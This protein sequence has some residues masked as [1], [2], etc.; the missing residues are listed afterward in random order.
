MSDLLAAVGPP[1]GPAAVLLCGGHAQNW[2]G[3][4]QV[5]T[6]D[7]VFVWRVGGGGGTLAATAGGIVEVE[8]WPRTYLATRRNKKV[9]YATEA[10]RAVGAVQA[11]PHG[12]AA[13]RSRAVF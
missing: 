11:V 3:G 8:R 5:P 4:L 10:A 7:P 6:G 9:V 12:G 1:V 13:R 2:S